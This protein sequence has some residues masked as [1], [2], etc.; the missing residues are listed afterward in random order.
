MGGGAG[1]IYMGGK[2]VVGVCLAEGIMPGDM[3][4]HACQAVTGDPLEASVAEVE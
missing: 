1:H 3:Q 2:R 4:E